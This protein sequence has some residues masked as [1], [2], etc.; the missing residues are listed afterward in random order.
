MGCL[1]ISFFIT[2]RSFETDLT[3]PLDFFISTT[4]VRFFIPGKF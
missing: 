4:P 3:V 2:V 1:K